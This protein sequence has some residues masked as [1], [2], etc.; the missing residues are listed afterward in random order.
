MKG[1]WPL[2][3]LPFVCSFSSHAQNV[4]LVLDN[5]RSQQGHIVVA[6]FYGEE[7]FKK[8]RPFIRERF[9]KT[10][11]ENGAMTV[12]LTLSPGKYGIAI[13]DDEDDDDY[14]TTNIIGYP[15][16]GFGFSGYFHSGLSR[17]KF[18]EFAFYVPDNLKTSIHCR[19][20]Y[21]QEY[22]VNKWKKEK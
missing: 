20:K 2:I 5:I 7:S 13:L 17:P 4:V 1:I 8:D 18:D 12:T 6:V 3:L 14:I 15:Q 19:I 16:E 21:M 11:M 10:E 9:G 22:P